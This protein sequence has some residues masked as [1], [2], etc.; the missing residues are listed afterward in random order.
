MTL[1]NRESS[2]FQGFPQCWSSSRRGRIPATTPVNAHIRH[3][4][5][6]HSRLPGLTPVFCS[7]ATHPPE[8]SIFDDP[9]M[10]DCWRRLL[11]ADSLTL[12]DLVA[13]PSKGRNPDDWRSRR[14][15]GQEN[16]SSPSANG[17]DAWS[18]ADPCES[19]RKTVRSTIG[20]DAAEAAEHGR[21][22]GVVARQLP[23]TDPCA[24]RTDNSGRVP[25]GAF[26]KT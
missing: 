25:R 19:R 9:H 1:R 21:Q 13:A 11:A 26:V 10:S 7:D 2:N 22:H 3:Y 5:I 8:R 24:R 23:S 6:W 18:A 17:D 14:H 12:P 4:P 16:W 20:S 15:Q